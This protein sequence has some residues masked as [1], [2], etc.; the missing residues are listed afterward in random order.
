MVSV[1]F[2]LGAISVVS[3][4]ALVS[5][6]GM[7]F[8]PANPLGS[9]AISSAN[10]NIL[11]KEYLKSADSP[12]SPIKG[13]YLDKRELDAMNQLAGENPGLSGFR[14]YFGKESTGVMVGVVV[15]VDANYNDVVTGNIYKTDSPKAGP[16]PTICDKTSPIIQQ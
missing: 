13:V 7:N 5:F 16:C 1:A 4:L 10:A 9:T 15:G 11:L 8:P 2:I 6:T 14:I 12:A 3:F